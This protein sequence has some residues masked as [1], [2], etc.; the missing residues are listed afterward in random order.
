MKTFRSFIKEESLLDAH[1]RYQEAGVPLPDREDITE[2]PSSPPGNKMGYKTGPDTFCVHSIDRMFGDGQ[3]ATITHYKSLPGGD[4]LHNI[5]GEAF[6]SFHN[7][8]QINTDGYFIH[9]NRVSKEEH[10]NVRAHPPRTEN[11]NI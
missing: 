8:K 3:T 4:V 2:Y 11:E 10:D 7:G 5:H 9:G 6:Q 1:I